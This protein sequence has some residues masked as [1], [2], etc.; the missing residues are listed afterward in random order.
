MPDD[1]FGGRAVPD[2]PVPAA[3]LVAVPVKL[4]L[5]TDNAMGCAVGVIVEF[6][7]TICGTPGGGIST[8]PRKMKMANAQGLYVPAEGKWVVEGPLVIAPAEAEAGED[9]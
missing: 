1:G 3:R 4:P 2:D 6:P 5:K 9:C 7:T 8:I